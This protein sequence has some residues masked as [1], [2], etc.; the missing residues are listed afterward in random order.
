MSQ[1][2]ARFIVELDIDEE[3][4]LA[5]CLIC[6]ERWETQD[7]E[8]ETDFLDSLIFHIGTCGM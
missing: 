8:T 4:W 3:K 6:G 1:N 5:T 7:G 2:M